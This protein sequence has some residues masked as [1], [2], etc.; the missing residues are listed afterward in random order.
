MRSVAG[1]QVLGRGDLLLEHADE[2]VHVV[3]PV[4]LDVQGVPAEAGSVREQHALRA[5]RRDVD[6]RPDGEG[7][8]AHVDRL[9]LRHV[10]GAG[11][12]DVAVPWRREQGPRREDDLQRRA[13]V[14]RERAVSAGL[15][16]PQVLQFAELL[17]VLP[18]QVVQLG[19]VD[20]HV[21]QLPRVV[22]EV[23]PPRDGGM[24]R[25]GLPALVP[26]APRA[27]HRV[28]L[29]R[30]RAV[31]LRVVEAVAHADAVEVA[32]HV[33]LDGVRDLDSR[34]SRGP[35]GRGRWRGGTAP[36][37]RP[38]PSCRPATR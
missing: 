1:R 32:L 34:G 36:G 13:V 2:T 30:A 10:G 25:H 23:A 15:R 4:L 35:S 7:T 11:E 27:E 22:V 12:V 8:V 5:R 3:Q 17:P 26:D 24:R 31:G 16:E 18:C 28:E 9:L 33:P 20:V 6:Q 14:E 29:G 38:G 21:V 37:S 19:A